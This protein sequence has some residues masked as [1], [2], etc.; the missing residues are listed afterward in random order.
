MQRRTFLKSTLQMGL[1]WQVDKS[2]GSEERPILDEKKVV[3]APKADRPHILLIMTDQQRGDALGCMGNKAV[4]SPHLDR[5]AQEGVLFVNGY[6]STP[7]STPARAGLLTG[8]SPWHHGMLGYGQV[9]ETYRYE[10]PR[11]LRDL[12]YY[13][14]GIGKMHWAPQTNLHGFHAT[15]LDESGRVESKDFISDYRK[16]F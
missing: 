2:L 8:M 1:A 3:A 13:T 10:M 9:S 14:M 6:S 5:L 11:M 12:G 16:W 15:L 4:R 7:S